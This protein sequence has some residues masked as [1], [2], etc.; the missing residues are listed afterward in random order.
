MQLQQFVTEIIE[1]LGGVVIPVEYGLCQVL[2]P[3]GY[4]HY[5]QNKSELELAF[6]F[7]VAQENP[8][9]EFV[10]FG[11]Y[12]LEQLLVITQKQ[13]TS[14]LRFVE[15]EQLKL[16]NPIKKITEFIG[17]EHGKVEVREERPVLGTWVVFQYHVTYVADERKETSKQVWVN[18]LTN[19]ICQMMEQ[20]QNRMIYQQEPFY[21]YPVRMV[22]DTIE[23]FHTATIYVKEFTDKQKEEQ[24]EVNYLQGD[25]D[26]ITNYYHELLVENERRAN[27]KGLSEEKKREILLK[28]EAIKLEGDKQLQ[29]I[30]QKYH[31]EIEINIDHGILYFV[32][33][34]E[35]QLEIQSRN[36]QERKD[37]YYNPI[38][39]GFFESKETVPLIT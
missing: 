29:E 34:L 2:I 26:R 21:T 28:S 6:D 31:G 23:A 5:F 16:G 12:V 33:L 13:A 30:K 25:I 3:E 8:T 9:S 27:R 7:E 10:T 19:E 20:N 38:T 39:K 24:M 32:P 36:H 18:L 4:T 17:R 14:T 1:G 22:V 11:S 35:L 37:I 15:V